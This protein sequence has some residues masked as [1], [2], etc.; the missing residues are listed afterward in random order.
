M[1]WS[2]TCKFPLRLELREQELMLRSSLPVP[3][4][5]CSSMI[6]DPIRELIQ[7]PIRVP[8]RDPP[9]CS[10]MI[11]DPIRVPIR[12]QLPCSS[13]RLT[14]TASTL[15]PKPSQVSP[16]SPRTPPSLHSTSPTNTFK[17]GEECKEEVI[18][19]NSHFFQPHLHQFYLQQHQWH[20]SLIMFPKTERIICCA[21]DPTT[22]ASCQGEGGRE[23][24][25]KRGCWRRKGWGAE[26]RW[27]KGNFEVLQKL[28]G[29]GEWE[30]G[31][32][33]GIKGREEQQHLLWVL[34][35]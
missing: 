26:E 2:L 27:T 12:D 6:K 8:I 7:D 31:C 30:E 1:F 23:E 21:G 5:P 9:P 4:P 29:G 32:W 34:Q 33:G 16:F 19:N 24:G 22:A 25:G 15:P 11:Q 28:W 13:M 18:L 17:A 10:S 20:Q 3:P 35:Q 14:S